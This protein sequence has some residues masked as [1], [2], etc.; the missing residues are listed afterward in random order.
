M[1]TII[2]RQNPARKKGD[3]ILIP[4]AKNYISIVGQVVNP[5]NIVYKQNFTVENYIETAG[6]FSWRAI[7]S[8]VRIIKANTGEWVEA[9]DIEQLEPGDII[10]V[11]EELPAPK[12]WDVFIDALTIFGQVAT[13]VA[14][15]VAVVIASRN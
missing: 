3:K 2:I 6:G 5:G 11:P 15:V 12:F 7:E 4:E 9:D 10:W 8:D 13:V 14:A 1:S